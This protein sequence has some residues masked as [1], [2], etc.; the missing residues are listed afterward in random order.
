MDERGKVY[1]HEA[2]FDALKLELHQ[3]MDALTFHS[4][5]RLNEEALRMDVLVIKKN[6]NTQVKK[7]IGQI[8]K[9][10]NIFEY[11]SESD[12]FSTWDYNKVLAYAYFYSAIEKV[13]MSDITITISLTIYPQKLIKTLESERGLTVKDMGDGVY[14]I[15]GEVV[16]IQILESKRLSQSTNLFLHNLRSNLCGTDLM[17]IIQSYSTQRSL[18]DKSAY[19]DRIIQ[20][21]L[22]AYKEALEMGALKEIFLQTADEKGWLDDRDRDRDKEKAKKIA[23]KMLL[24]GHPL[25]EIVDMTELSLETVKSL[26]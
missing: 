23:Q 21:N 9:G 18:N 26:A 1:W 6:A 10:S 11:K 16:P 2:F 7:N 5:Y 4:E 17:D 3:Y 24:R 20:A 22:Q 25:E 12:Y 15:E 13:P 14:Y 19:L 8:F